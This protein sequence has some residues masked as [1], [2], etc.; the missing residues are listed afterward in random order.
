M[1]HTLKIFTS[2]SNMKAEIKKDK[3]ASDNDVKPG[4]D[5]PVLYRIFA[6]FMA[7]NKKAAPPKKDDRSEKLSQ[8][9]VQMKEDES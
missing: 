1:E 9:P 8:M 5:E 3:L 6:N 7:K 4:A 2:E